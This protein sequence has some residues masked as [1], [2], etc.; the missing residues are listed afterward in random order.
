VRV[1]V[2]VGVVVVA[3]LVAVV[4]VHGIGSGAVGNSGSRL[5]STSS[6]FRFTWWEQAWHGFREHPLRGVGAGAFHLLNLRFRTSYLDF[7]IEPH[8][9][10]IQLLA[11]VGVIG[12]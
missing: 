8:D 9:L 11:E 10:P 7:T 6:N 3:A 12:L 5:G 2:V 1:L 4:A